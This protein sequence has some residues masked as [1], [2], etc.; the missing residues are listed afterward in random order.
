MLK[1]IIT[2][3]CNR[4]C[5]YCINRNIPSIHKGFTP[6][7]DASDMMLLKEFYH[8]LAEQQIT[9]GATEA[10]IMITGG[11]PMLHPKTSRI[12]QVA[13]ECFDSVHIT[14]QSDQ[15][16]FLPLHLLDSITFTLHDLEEIVKIE[17][18]LYLIRM[19]TNKSIPMPVYVSILA[20]KYRSTLPK[21]LY[22]IGVSGLTINEEQRGEI[23]T[24]ISAIEKT[25]PEIE[26]F[27]YKINKKGHCINETIILPDLIIVTD[28][29]KY[30]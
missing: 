19:H 2:T 27:S 9:N 18:A 29:N 15:V 30:L 8:K 3:D 6:I 1:H 5:T 10:K 23:L 14:T 12:L 4:K 20:D 28:F 25:L 24:D 16:F 26:G 17:K 21:E 22:D 13:W 11:E 7:K